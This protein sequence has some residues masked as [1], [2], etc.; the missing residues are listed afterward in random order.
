MKRDDWMTD[1]QWSQACWIEHNRNRPATDFLDT[2][3]PASPSLIAEPVTSRIECDSS[4]CYAVIVV[5]ND[6]DEAQAATVARGAGW[7]AQLGSR[8]F[9]FRCQL[10]APVKR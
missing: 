5:P 10:H 1:E 2:H 7:H 8:R 9:Y 3:R 6:I 4:G